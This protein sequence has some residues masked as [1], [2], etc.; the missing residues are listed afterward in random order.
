MMCISL[1]YID[2]KSSLLLSFQI[3]KA[4]GW[5]FCINI[6]PIP[7]PEESHSTTKGFAKY[8]VA[9]T[10]VDDITIFNVSKHY[11]TLLFHW[12]EFFFNRFDNGVVK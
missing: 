10:G 5:P 4:I 8:G 7:K 1:L 3:L 6:A 2:F 9:N 12:K 11:S